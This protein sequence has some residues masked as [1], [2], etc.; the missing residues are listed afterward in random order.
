[1]KKIALFCI[2]AFA[3]GSI[4]CGGTEK[5]DDPAPTEESARDIQPATSGGME[6]GFEDEAAV[7]EA[8]V[9]EATGDEAPA[10]EAPATPE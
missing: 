4:A 3:A 6:R 1:M 2:I 9:E 8:P 7:E 10:E 5:K